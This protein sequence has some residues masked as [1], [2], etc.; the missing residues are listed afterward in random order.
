[1]Y[2][3]TYRCIIYIY[4]VEGILFFIGKILKKKGFHANELWG[5]AQLVEVER[6]IT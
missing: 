1:M 6:C 4:I 5:T 3:L 2:T